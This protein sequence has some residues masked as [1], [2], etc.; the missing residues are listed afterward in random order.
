LESQPFSEKIR[1]ASDQSFS[2]ELAVDGC[3]RAGFSPQ[4]TE[5]SLLTTVTTF[6]ESELGVSLVLGSFL[7]RVLHFDRSPND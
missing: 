5:P 6:V 7:K 1:L 2:S 3:Q 4:V